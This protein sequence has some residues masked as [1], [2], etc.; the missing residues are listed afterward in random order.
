MFTRF[1]EGLGSANLSLAS[2]TIGNL[3]AP[4]C[5]DLCFNYSV[6]LPGI[7]FLFYIVSSSSLGTSSSSNGP[8]EFIGEND[9]STPGASMEKLNSSCRTVNFSDSGIYRLLLVAE[10]VRITNDPAFAFLDSFTISETLCRSRGK[11]EMS[12][13]ECYDPWPDKKYIPN[14]YEQRKGE[15]KLT[16]NFLC[17]LIH[18]L[19]AE[20]VIIGVFD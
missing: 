10:K 4:K 5:F 8:N 9:E 11:S 3:S 16:I 20:S 1:E 15:K 14:M 6:S 18:Y 17:C 19:T 12:A 2:F 7:Q 13:N